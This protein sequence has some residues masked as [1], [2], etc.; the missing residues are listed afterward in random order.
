M[1]VVHGLAAIG[2]SKVF[3]RHPEIVVSNLNTWGWIV[4]CLGALQIVAA[5]GISSGN[6]L[7]RWFGVAVAF[8]NAL[9]QLTFASAFPIW[10]LT[11][12]GLDILVIYGLI[13]HGRAA[14]RE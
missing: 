8:L 1:N 12:F 11:I 5:I 6:R 7:A 4:L 9:C 3:S 14:L 10:S 2:N 13:V